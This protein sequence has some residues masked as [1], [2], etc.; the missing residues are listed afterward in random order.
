MKTKVLQARYS[1]G[2]GLGRIAFS[3]KRT[4]QIMGAFNYQ[5]VD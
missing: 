5:L 4:W 1:T 2:R 3:R